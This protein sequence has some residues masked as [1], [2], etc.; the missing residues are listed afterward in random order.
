MTRITG[1]LH[2]VLYIFLITSRSVVLRMRN[3]ADK[4]YRENQNS[5]FMFN[6]FFKPKIIPLMR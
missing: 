3:V 2:E 6:N 1:T 5:Y 4:N